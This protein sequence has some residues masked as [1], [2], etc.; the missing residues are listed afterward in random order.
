[1][2]VFILINQNLVVGN[3][4]VPYFISLSVIIVHQLPFF[5]NVAMSLGA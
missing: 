1:M 2:H 3:I 5:T 4:S